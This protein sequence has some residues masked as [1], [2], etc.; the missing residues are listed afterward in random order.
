MPKSWGSSRLGRSRRQAREAG[1]PHCLQNAYSSAYPTN[2][3]QMGGCPARGWGN[4]G[5]QR[6][7]RNF[8]GERNVPN[9]DGGGCFPGVDI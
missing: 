2:K 3:K 6:G 9:L 1:L 4:I 5:L 8:G 7:S